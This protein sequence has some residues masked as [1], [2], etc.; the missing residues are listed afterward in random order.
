MHAEENKTQSLTIDNHVG[1]EKLNP[2]ISILLKYTSW[3]P[4]KSYK[5][6]RSFMFSV[7]LLSDDPGLP[8]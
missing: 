1:E 2:K 7:Y 8:L 6:Q 4:P 3:N 5:T